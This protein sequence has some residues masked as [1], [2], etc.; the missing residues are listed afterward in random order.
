MPI[1]RNLVARRYYP[2]TTEKQF[3]T[4][5]PLTPISCSASGKNVID[6]SKQTSTS[7]LILIILWFF[8][9]TFAQGAREKIYD[10]WFFS[11]CNLPLLTVEWNW[12]NFTDQS[13]MQSCY[14]SVELLIM[15]NSGRSL[16]AQWCGWEPSMKE[17][18]LRECLLFE[19]TNS[20]VC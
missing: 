12:M 6:K 5:K 18:S 3:G 4:F 11:Q 9:F 15:L 1:K 14:K 17:T 8:F 2:P 20:S 10:L 7:L 13:L 19:T 16:K